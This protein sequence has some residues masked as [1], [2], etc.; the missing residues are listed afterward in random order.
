MK[1]MLIKKDKIKKRQVQEPINWEIKKWKKNNQITKILLIKVS[2]LFNI[3]I[4]INKS[5]NIIDHH[6]FKDGMVLIIKYKY[7]NLSMTKWVQCLKYTGKQNQK[8]WMPS[9]LCSLEVWNILP[10]K[11]MQS[12]Y[13][14]YLKRNWNIILHFWWLIFGVNKLF[15]QNRSFLIEIFQY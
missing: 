12:S 10:L 6:L 9:Y 2:K 15:W 1:I 4:M 7:F 13:I 14:R 5:N 11:M 8:I 3:N